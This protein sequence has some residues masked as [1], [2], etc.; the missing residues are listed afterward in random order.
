MQQ[1]FQVPDRPSPALLR[2]LEGLASEA[3]SPRPE[4]TMMAYF[5]LSQRVIARL[6]QLAQWDETLRNDGVV[7]LHLS[8]S[9]LASMVGA[10]REK[11][12]RALAPLVEKGLVRLEYR[13]MLLP[14]VE[15]LRRLQH[16]EGVESHP[17]HRRPRPAQG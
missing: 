10:T 2:I 16:S 13:R 4:V 1:T 12:N 14:D 5:P 17:R 3:R 9:L 7:E 8:Q 6:V 11:V 15:A